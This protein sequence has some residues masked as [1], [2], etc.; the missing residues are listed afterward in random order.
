M[1]SFISNRS[2][3]DKLFTDGMRQTLAKEWD[4]IY[5][6]DLGGDLRSQLAVGTPL[7]VGSPF[8]V[9]NTKGNIKGN[10]FGIQTGVAICFLLK[11]TKPPTQKAAAQNTG[12]KPKS[13][14]IFYYALD[15]YLSGK[16]KLAA[17]DELGSATEIQQ[18]SL[19]EEIL[20][21]TRGSWLHQGERDFANYI[22]MGAKKPQ[23]TESIFT[24]YSN[25][26]KS[27]RDEWVYDFCKEN[28]GKKMQFFIANYEAVRK[29]FAELNEERKKDFQEKGHYNELSEWTGNEIKWS[30][31]LRERNLLNDREICYEV[32]KIICSLYRPFVKKFLYYDSETAIIDQTYQTQHIFGATGT[33]ENICINV[34]CI[35]DDKIVVFA[36]SLI[37]DKGLTKIGNGGNFLLPSL[38]LCSAPPRRYCCRRG[39]QKDR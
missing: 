24:L 16:Q 25:G 29:R 4:V 7:A 26:V 3:I 32:G 9:G 31:D 34:S 14:R 1:L 27:N 12:K 19:F 20:P 38:S 6:V 10:I 36:N 22:R 17:L 33:L 8:A 37:A 11:E 35:G 21:D 23:N 13:A 39:P 30:R 2:Y 5:I 15:D 28:I 18:R